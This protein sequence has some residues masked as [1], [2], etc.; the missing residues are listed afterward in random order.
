MNKI[1]FLLV[2]F[3]L[4]GCVQKDLEFTLPM[5]DNNKISVLA[6]LQNNS[7]FSL[8]IS[9]AIPL[10]NDP[11]DYRVDNAIPVLYENGLPID[12]LYFDVSGTEQEN[13]IR[14]GF[15]ITSDTIALIDGS[16]YHIEIFTPELM[17]AKSL[18]VQYT[19]TLADN[20]TA[21]QTETQV[22]GNLVDVDRKFWFEVEVEDQGDYV[23]SEFTLSQ[24][25]NPNADLLR[26]FPFQFNSNR[27]IFDS[28][29]PV[30]T[31]E[32]G[33][34]G[35]IDTLFNRADDP[36]CFCMKFQN[37]DYLDFAE[38][39]GAVSRENIGGLDALPNELPSNI[40]NG[41]GFFAIIDSQCACVNQ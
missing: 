6:V 1:I 29:L 10:N 23:L 3:W 18:P 4:V 34:S 13:L 41:F 8:L 36:T 39:L 17:D 24:S 20:F 33:Y 21:T 16:T 12:T 7:R 31:Y 14:N 35:I 9:R 26:R 25:T 11:L 30:G 2:S 27:D 19:R 28:N 37:K 5:I 15:Y 32:G 22:S 40:V 38:A